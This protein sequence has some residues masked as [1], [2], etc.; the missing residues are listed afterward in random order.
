MSLTPLPLMMIEPLVRAALLEDL[1]RAGDVT[2]NAIAPADLIASAALTARQLGVVA[3]MDLAALAFRM[4]DP[5]VEI[6]TNAQ[7]AT[8]SRRGK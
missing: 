3:G 4:V 2:S 8:G 6:T 7:M 1:G 5:T